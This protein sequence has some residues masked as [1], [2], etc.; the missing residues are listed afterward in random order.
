MS[1]PSNLYAEKIYSEHPTALWA[2]DDKLDYVS[3]ITEAQRNISSLWTVTNATA[4]TNTTDLNQPFSD[5]TKTKV[6]VNNPSTP[7]LQASLISPNLV[8]F[9][10]LS[11]DLKTFS[12]SAY[13]YSSSAYV[14]S[15]SIGYEYTDTTSSL[16][17]QELKTYTSFPFQVWGL[18]S[19]T[20]EIPDENTNLRAVIKIEVNDGG[21]SS[22]YDFYINGVT[23]GQW[24][25]NFNSSSLGITPIAFPSSIAINHDYAVEADSY[26]L[27]GQKGY[28]LVNNK[29]L[30]SSNT[31][32]PLVYGASNVTRLT[33]NNGKPSLIVPGNGFLNKAGKNK[34]YTVEFWA[35][36]NSNASDPK[37]I[38]GPI[39]STDGLY[40][41]SGFLTFVIGKKFQSHFIG[42]WYRPMLIQV[43][44]TENNA[45]V[46]LNGEDIISFSITSSEL[47]FPDILNASGKQ[48]DWLGFYA[49][50]DITPIEIDCVAIYSYSVPAIVAKR[51]F[52][53]GQ[54]VSSAEGINSSYNGTSAFID[55]PFSKYSSNYMYP[56][57]A[58]WQQGAFDNLSTT[59]TA[60]TSPTYSLP[61]IFT[62]DKTL[63]NLYDDNQAIQV[64]LEDKFIT[65]RPNS[66]WNNK[67]CYFNFTKLSILQNQIDAIY[68]VFSSDNLVSEETLVKIYNAANSNYFIIKKVADEIVYELYFGG[69]TTTIYTTTPIVSDEKFSVG[70]N[71]KRLVDTFGSNLSSFFGNQSALKVYVCGDGNVSNQF[72]G[73]MYS[74]G[75]SSSYN[76]NN[77]LDYF[78]SNGIAIIDDMSVTS[79][80]NPTNAELLLSHTASYTLIP[81][82]AYG[83]YLLDIG[84]NGYWQDYLPLS[85]FAKYVSDKNNQQVYDID[86]LQFNIGY[87]SPTS[88]KELETTDE[89]SWTYQE[90]HNQFSSPLQR[91]YA[92]LDNVLFT[93]WNDYLEMSQNSIKYYEY[94]TSNALIR[95]YVSFQYI[96]NG[97]NAL[98]E[99]FTH[100][101]PAR[102]YSI[103]DANLNANWIETKYEVIDNTIIYPIKSVDFNDIALVC[104]LEFNIR[105]ILTKP[106]K[107]KK[108]EIASQSFN[109]NSFNPIG[110]RFGVDL[111]P[112]KKSGVYFD[113][114]SKNPIS[115][116]KG[117]SP[118]LYLTRKTGI[119]VRGENDLQTSRG[120]S[121]PINS[122][123]SDDFKVSAIQMWIRPDQDQLPGTETEIFEVAYKDD[124]IKFYM[125]ADSS[126]ANRAKIVAKKASNN[127]EFNGI[128]YY[129]NGNLVSYPVITTKE[130]G[131]LGLSFANPLSYNSFLGSVNLTAPLLFN[132]ISYYKTSNLQDIQGILARPWL[133]VLEQTVSI[134]YDWDYWFTSFTWDGVLVKGYTNPYAINPADIYKT[135]IGTNKIIIDDNEGLLLDADKMKIHSEAIWESIVKIPV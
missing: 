44:V 91:T 93:G 67:N 7:T 125:V 128:A 110:T 86:F 80:P 49:Y 107:L 127:Q 24:S 135:Y 14:K 32:V 26:G 28:Y 8:N 123:L 98:K 69:T 53:Y 111:F 23:V 38:F 41:E 115:I 131:I 71:I 66:S 30:L 10:S 133:E 4:T 57:F 18:V 63:Q 109:D 103:V 96:E 104:H 25:E 39:A 89:T 94:D 117:S 58:K 97:A 83:S 40:V 85:Y 36:I 129:W 55:Y 81:I 12:V 73:K 47:D 21:T 84:V 130:W 120:L 105:G 27:G 102:E 76:A 6:V 51:R 87:P 75:I 122:Q 34:I 106:I 15:I 16:I 114:K 116:Y 59:T 60:V 43:K 134:D 35:R 45:S 52:V 126:N 68:G 65:F 70:I 64:A 17:V 99:S 119:E 132:N 113:Y 77:I 79:P 118:Y 9:Q 92:Q 22:D 82:E 108:L 42:E 48:Q 124:T 62:E 1:N 78:E 5:S 121:M 13:I 29:Y 2:L 31:S 33:P 101:Q 74:F 37:R 20:F 100:T 56:D 3:L 19:S 72:T 54:G 88:L 11:T 61:E 112:Y 46:I 50:D 90:L 95:S